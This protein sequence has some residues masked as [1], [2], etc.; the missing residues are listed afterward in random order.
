MIFRRTAMAVLMA[1]G[2][3]ALGAATTNWNNTV[4]RVDGGHRIGNPDAPV[5][6]TEYVSYTCS[7]CA[8]FTRE[9]QDALKAGYVMPGKMSLEIRHL[10][11]DPV[12]L[13]AAVLANC[14]PAAKF[15]LNHS[16]FMLGQDKWMEAA[17]NTT[18]AQ[19]QRWYSGEQA[20]RRRAIASDLGFYAIMER[21]GYSRAD[22]D[23]CLNDNATAEQIADVSARDWK[24]PG[25]GGTPSFAI[26]DTVLAGTHSWSLL[27][28]QLAARLQ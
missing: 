28:P 26:N 9:A 1:V 12:D 11:R 21:R 6:L 10:I 3:V 17:R 20:A 15:P 7:H 18:K 8:D 19:Q 25:I 16:A 4:A 13:T 14:G 23:R 5:K 22:A 2:A 24:K 27:S